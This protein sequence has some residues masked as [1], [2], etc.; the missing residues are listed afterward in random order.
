MFVLHSSG[1]ICLVRVL[2][3]VVDEL[4][5]GKYVKSEIA[6]FCFSKRAARVL[7]CCV[8]VLLCYA[9][10]RLRLS[11]LPVARSAAPGRCAASRWSS[12]PSTAAVG[13]YMSNRDDDITLFPAQQINDAE[14]DLAPLLGLSIL[15]RPFRAWTKQYLLHTSEFLS[16]HNR[17]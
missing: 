9:Y 14:N 3:R 2:C 17:M 13:V 8:V 15:F 16:S 7:P 4:A 12:C 11:A 1:V 10:V 5:F 6:R